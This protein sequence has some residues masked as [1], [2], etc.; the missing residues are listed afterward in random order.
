MIIVPELNESKV[1]TRL[2]SCG[3]LGNFLKSHTVLNLRY[4]FQ[5]M[6]RGLSR[7]GLV[8]LRFPGV[9]LNPNSDEREY[10]GPARNTLALIK[11]S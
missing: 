8:K 6:R 11:G 9:C 1:L 3:I 2:K 5:I 4:V 10:G 7:A